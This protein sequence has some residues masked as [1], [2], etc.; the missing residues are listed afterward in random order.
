[1]VM[2][3]A[4]P[5]QLRSKDLFNLLHLLDADSFPFE[6]SF[7]QT[8]QA[9]APIVAL[10]DQVLNGNV[11]REAFVEALT[12]AV[13]NRIF[14]DNEQ[15][16]FLLH[17]PPRDEDLASPRGRSEIADQLD[18]INPLTKVVTRTLKR[19]VQE[20]RVERQ[21][22]TI[23]AT[24][25]PIERLFYEQ[26][27][28]AVR[29]YCSKFAM[30][31]GFM[32]TIPQRQMSSC[33]AAACKG[34]IERA[35][36]LDDE[37][38][39]EQ[40]FDLFGD[41]DEKTKKP[42]LGPLL[43]TLVGIARQVGDHKLLEASDSKYSALVSNI[44]AYWR[45]Y[46]GKKI[47]L[48]SFYRNTLHYLARRLAVDHVDSVVLHG[49]MDKQGALR[50]FAS[51]SGPNIL[52][53][54]E[55]AAEGVD[56]QF[57]SLVIN[58]DLPWNP[59]RIEQRIGRIDRIGQE[60]EKILIWNLIYDDTVDERIYVRLLERLDI[61]RQALGSMESMLGDEIRQLTYE[62]LSHNLSPAQEIARI[63]RSSVALETVNRQQTELESEATQ[64]IAHGD[65]I[66]NKVRAARELGRYV[67]G[68]DL[69]A[70]VRD[71]FQREFPGT[72]FVA[73]DAN[74]LEQTVELSIDG[75][76][77]FSDFL[78][79]HRLQ[80]STR[81]LA[82]PPPLLLFENLLGRNTAG[83]ERVTQ[84]HPLVRFVAERLKLAGGGPTYSP[85]S[86][87]ELLA[88]VVGDISPGAYVYSIARWTVSGSRDV[89]RLE[90]LLK[91]LDDESTIDG[92]QAEFLI[93]AAGLQGKDWLGVGTM[94]DHARTAAVWEN[95]RGELEARFQLFREA[96]LRENRDRISLMVNTLQHHL[97]SQSRTIIERIARYRTSENQRQHRMIPAEEGRLK[98]LR[99]RIESKISEL[100][101]KETTRAQDSMVSGGVIRIV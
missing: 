81:I 85:V 48:F 63:D 76:V 34:W 84:D 16:E 13:G 39:D 17:N 44:K 97:A 60:A 86:A 27:T 82:T 10:R 4:T 99:L 6:S 23:R 11:T 54:S 29:D 101:L 8:L 22:V 49:G 71:F 94:L 70:Y 32:L 51:A 100:R 45:D 21:P 35:G 77:V 61:F 15:I 24:M 66:Q 68:E 65:F 64:L 95:C 38:I 37:D 7:G 2:L 9:N 57:S 93:N 19:E 78:Q 1:M 58:Y 91:R 14:D 74:L 67:R 62:L 43:Q 26:V 90:Y 53:S 31:E 20:M 36:D 40:V 80:G 50:H 47:I 18:R 56:L 46:P 96:Q 5:I 87:V 92:E 30:S 83:R 52:L 98:K 89:E 75:R 41:P 42:N 55:V 69:L 33:I 25:N 79:N 59:S 88:N 73:T 3:S 28:S 12:V 72:R